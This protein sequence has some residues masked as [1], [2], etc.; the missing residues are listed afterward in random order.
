M[1]GRACQATVR[2]PE[3]TAVR[4]GSAPI[5]VVGDPALAKVA[6]IAPP[7]GASGAGKSERDLLTVPEARHGLPCDCGALFGSHT[8]RHHI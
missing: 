1:S 7:P 4:I 8:L 6:G 2:G 5:R 3:L